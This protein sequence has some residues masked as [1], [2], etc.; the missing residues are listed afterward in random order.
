ME[1]INELLKILRPYLGWNKARLYCLSGIIMSLMVV[2]TV[3]LS[4][5]SQ[6]F[7]SKAS[8]SS[9]YKRFQRFFRTFE[10]DY[11]AIAH[12]VLSLFDQL[13]KKIYLTIDRTNWKFGKANINIFMVGIVYKGI[14]L[15]LAWSLLDKRGNSNVSE[16]ISLIDICL[17]FIKKENILGILGDREFIGD[18]WFKY[19][20]DAEIPLY[21][22]L[23]HNLI[24]NVNGREIKISCLFR[25]LKIGENRVLRN[26]IKIGNHAL[27]LSATRLAGGEFLI[28][29]STENPDMATQIYATRW[30][31]ETLFGCF[32]TRGFCFEDTHIT[33][34]ARI[35][36]MIAVLAISFCWAHKTGEWRAKNDP[37]II[38]NHGRKIKSIFRHG[39][40]FITESISK[41]SFMPERVVQC[42]DILREALKIHWENGATTA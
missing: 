40:D 19:L 22:R 24:F 41:I 26:K 29:G 20:I 9:T 2:K 34:Q 35:K 13:D 38:K 17:T 12:F 18:A 7:Q 5:L 6:F 31:I 25:D 1:H 10:I 15:P 11:R 36:K 23:K 28:I 3:N 39:L 21:I 37:I 30:E 27:Y 4:K 14:A 8:A 32:K 33:N 16:R 42:L